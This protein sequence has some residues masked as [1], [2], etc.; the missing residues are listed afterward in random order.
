MRPR[1]RPLH[2]AAAALCSLVFLTGCGTGTGPNTGYAD[3]QDTT[4]IGTDSSAES[5]VVAALYGELLTDAGVEVKT[6]TTRYASPAD[7]A[8]AVVEG[9]IGLAPAYETTMLRALPGGQT[10]PGNM[11]ATLSMALPPGI[12]ALAPA[13]AQ[14]GLVV[15]VTRATAREHGLSS[16][17]DLAEA[18]GR[19]TLGGS[20]SGDPDAPSAA[21]L[22]KAYGVTL[23]PAGTSKT[24]D[25]RVLRSTDPA[26]T[27]DGLVVLTDP[28]SVVPPEHVFPLAG[29]PYASVSARKALA[30]INSRLTTEELAELAASVEAGASPDETARDW[31]RAED[32]LG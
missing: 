16:L 10:M 4:V 22:K 26:L 25:V 11:K 19:L 15:A 13:K 30:R 29:A 1:L 32:L 27:R 2:L 12:V 18:D 9:E 20:A 21:E 24:A 14:H 17:A 6:A 8:H 7:T 23:A 5:R 31:L 28:K 3:R